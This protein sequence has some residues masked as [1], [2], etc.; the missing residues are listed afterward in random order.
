MTGA[1]EYSRPFGAVPADVMTCSN[2]TCAA[3][4]AQQRKRIDQKRENAEST[5]FRRFLNPLVGSPTPGRLVTN[6]VDYRGASRA[7]LQAETGPVSV[8]CASLRPRPKS[9]AQSPAIFAAKF[10]RV[11][12]FSSSHETQ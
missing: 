4:D 11:Y 6:A 9:R 5:H 10:G 8:A 7:G 3:R 2:A 1:G 12:L